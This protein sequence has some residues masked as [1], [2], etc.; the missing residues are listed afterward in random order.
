VDDLVREETFD[1]TYHASRGERGWLL[2]ILGGFYREGWISDI[3]HVVQA[4]KEAT[5]YCCEADPSHGRRLVAAKVYRPATQRT[6]RND[7]IYK[8]GRPLIDENGRRIT[9]QR[10]RRAVARHTRYGRRAERISWIEHE[11]QTLV[12][13]HAAG[14]DVPEPL[15]QEG[16]AML[17]EYLGERG[18]AAPLLQSV[19]LEPDEAQRVWRRL[20]AN[21][22]TMLACGR[23]HADLSAFNVLYWRG[24]PYIIDLPQA[25][26]GRWNSS[27]LS[28]LE[29][30]LARLGGYFR[31]YGVEVDATDLA[32]DL[33]NRYLAVDR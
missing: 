17:M 14:A 12:T 10:T 7:A 2:D 28:L 1:F 30:D 4:G 29:R 6:M 32:L 22:E 23:I 5:V 13:L 25:V 19:H 11:Y 8:E 20:L 24:R 9:D 3:L 18:R 16:N 31:R 27:A 21:V 33:W 15:A 26:D